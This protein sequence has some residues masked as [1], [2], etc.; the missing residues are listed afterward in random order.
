MSVLWKDQHRSNWH[1][2]T[3]CL[4]NVNV[5]HILCSLFYDT[6]EIIFIGLKRSHA[7]H[8]DL[9]CSDDSIYTRCEGIMLS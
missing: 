1:D 9:V 5:V 2:I 3:V 8:S 7:L 4:Y 6:I